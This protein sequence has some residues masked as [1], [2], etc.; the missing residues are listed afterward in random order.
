MLADHVLVHVDQ[1]G[2]S[3]D[4]EIGGFFRDGRDLLLEQQSQKQL[5]AKHRTDIEATITCWLARVLVVGFPEVC[6]SLKALL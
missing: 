2:H 6:L 4:G 3:D 1:P 5:G